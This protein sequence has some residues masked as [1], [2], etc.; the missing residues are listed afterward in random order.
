ML[1]SPPLKPTTHVSSSSM[2]RVCPT[3]PP[4]SASPSF[5]HFLSAT[6]CFSHRCSPDHAGITHPAPITWR[7]PCVYMD[8]GAVCGSGADVW[9]GAI[10]LAATAWT[11]SRIPSLWTWN[12]GSSSQFFCR[13]PFCTAIRRSSSLP[14]Q[15]RNRQSR[16]HPQRRARRGQQP[17]MLR[18]PRAQNPRNPPLSR[19]LRSQP[20]RKERRTNAKSS[21]T[22][23][24]CRSFSRIAAVACCTGGSRHF[25]DRTGNQVDLVPTEVP[26]DQPR[27]FSLIVNDGTLTQ[28]INSALYRVSGDTNGHVDATSQPAQL[29]FEYRG[30]WWPACAQGVRFRAERTTS[31]RCRRAPAR[32]QVAAAGN[33]VGAW[34]WRRGR[35]RGGRQLFHRQL[36]ATAG[37]DLS[38]RR[39]LGACARE[40]VGRR[41]FDERAISVRRSR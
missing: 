19:L 30:R 32:E 6:S 1:P 40:Q 7:R 25:K 33:R 37:G 3:G 35:A 22:R 31:S 11:R 16:R 28:R 2:R 9:H 13:L 38:S 23:R 20:R 39:K 21:S 8:R 14:R 26:S 5:W 12:V 4:Q 17:Q 36:H 10:R 15:R 27:P 34:T 29:V 18:L 41:G 24:R